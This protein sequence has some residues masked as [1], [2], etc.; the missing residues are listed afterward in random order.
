MV[1]INC[2]CSRL[3]PLPSSEIPI[4]LIPLHHNLG[5]RGP[6]H[7][8]CCLDHPDSFLSSKQ[9]SSVKKFLQL[10]LTFLPSGHQMVLLIT[11]LSDLD[12]LI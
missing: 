8:L 5:L 11:V 3:L 12:K 7:T 10:S 9:Q 6:S 1:N 2:H 4:G